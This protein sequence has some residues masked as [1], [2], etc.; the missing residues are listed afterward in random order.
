MNYESC[1]VRGLHYP[2]RLKMREIDV[3]LTLWSSFIFEK[4]IMLSL[5]NMLEPLL[6][7]IVQFV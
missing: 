5:K 3:E 7:L 4:N 2:A 1:I 6:S